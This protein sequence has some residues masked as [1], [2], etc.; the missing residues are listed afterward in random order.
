VV[1]I[2]PVFVIYPLGAL[3]SPAFVARLAAEE[4]LT[5]ALDASRR[6]EFER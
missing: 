4:L 3:A 6:V 1:P 5:G 2:V